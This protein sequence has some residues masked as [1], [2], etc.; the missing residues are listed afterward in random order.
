MDERLSDTGLLHETTRGEDAQTRAFAAELIQARLAIARLAAERDEL[1]TANLIWEG[2]GLNLRIADL[3]DFL[4]VWAHESRLQSFEDR[5]R[6]RVAADEHLRGICTLHV[7]R[8]P[9]TWGNPRYRVPPAPVDID[10]LLK[11]S[12]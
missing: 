9:Q 3:E 4:R 5:E 11:R 12:L 7:W 6:F 8:T 10:G 1:K 2:T